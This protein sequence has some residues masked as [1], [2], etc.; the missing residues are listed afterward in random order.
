MGLRFV[1]KMAYLWPM[2]ISKLTVFS[3]KTPILIYWLWDGGWDG[4]ESG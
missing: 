3:R 2:A 1:F 4:P